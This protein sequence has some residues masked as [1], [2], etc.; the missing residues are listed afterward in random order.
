MGWA[1]GAE[2]SAA[3]LAAAEAAGVTFTVAEATAIAGALEVGTAS[4]FDWAIVG[5]LVKSVATNF[6]LSAALSPFA[7]R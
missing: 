3:E 1:T 6:A 2:I 5:D 7:N 4:A